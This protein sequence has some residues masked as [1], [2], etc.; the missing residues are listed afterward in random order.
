MLNSR[1]CSTCFGGMRVSKVG[2]FRRVDTRA[3]FNVLERAT[4]SSFFQRRKV[5][6][7]KRG[8]NATPISPVEFTGDNRDTYETRSAPVPHRWRRTT[9]FVG[10]TRPRRYR[11]RVYRNTSRSSGRALS[12]R[13]K[14]ECFARDFWPITR[15]AHGTPAFPR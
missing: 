7:A 4:C 3:S 13:R 11:S 1:A 8:K 14:C 9:S 10:R 15:A 6:L 2:E 12:L 5:L